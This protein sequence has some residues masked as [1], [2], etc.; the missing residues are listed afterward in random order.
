M[1]DASLQVT[2]AEPVE[3]EEQGRGVA[4]QLADT[5]VA[6]AADEAGLEHMDLAAASSCTTTCRTAA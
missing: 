2:P 6:A 1:G 4:R 5:T 3:A